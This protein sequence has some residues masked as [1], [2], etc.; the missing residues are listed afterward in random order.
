D[1]ET[2]RGCQAPASPVLAPVRRSKC[3]DHG[4]FS[5][6]KTQ[7]IPVCESY[8]CSAFFRTPGSPC[9]STGRRFVWQESEASLGLFEALFSARVGRSKRLACCPLSWMKSD[10]RTKSFRWRTVCVRWAEF[11]RP[12]KKM[13][14]LF[15]SK[16]ENA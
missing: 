13:R 11:F 12:A 4:G 9:C 1:G 6:R 3:R 14:F 2:A 16:A 7:A 10:W 15:V 5:R 8:V